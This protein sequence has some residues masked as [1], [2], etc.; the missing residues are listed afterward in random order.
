[1]RV[2]RIISVVVDRPGHTGRRYKTTEIY[3]DQVTQACTR[4]PGSEWRRRRRSSGSGGTRRRGTHRSRRFFF[5]VSPVGP[6]RT[7]T[8]TGPRSTV[9]AF[10]P[11]SPCPSHDPLSLP[12]ASLT[13]FPLFL[14][15]VPFFSRS[16]SLLFTAFIQFPL[17]VPLPFLRSS[18][19]RFFSI[20]CSTITI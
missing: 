2:L 13:A 11:A 8:R 17:F 7:C 19:V 4:G 20:S 18:S 6:C 15:L 16:F 1:M 5:F 9:T 3:W 10:H 12:Y 14:L